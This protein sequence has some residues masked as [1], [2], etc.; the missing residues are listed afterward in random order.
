MNF[1]FEF[2]TFILTKKL[3]SQYNNYTYIPHIHFPTNI[4]N[5]LYKLLK[6]NYIFQ[7]SSS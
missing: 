5:N 2:G 7:T 1:A 3:Q 4:K 6:N